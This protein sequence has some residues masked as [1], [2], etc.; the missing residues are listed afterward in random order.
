M[1]VWLEMPRHRPDGRHKASGWTT[2][3]SAFQISQKFFPEMSRVR[4]VLSCRPDSRTL[5]ARN[6]HIK[7][8][9]VW[10]KGSIV[11]TVDLMHTISIYEVR[12]S[13]PW[14]LTSGRLDFECMTCLMDERVRTGIHIVWTIAA[15]FPYLC[16]GKKYH[17]WLNTECRP[18]VLLKHPDGCKLEKFEASRHRGR[19]GR[20]VLIV[21]TDDAWTVKHLDGISRR[22][23]SCKG[24]DFTDL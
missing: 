17:S 5:A 15:V 20:K 6:F 10:T 1:S 23:D 19:S 13:E 8:W 11:L 9:R 14:G 2:V 16:F 7:G 21:R 18:D 22:L 3:R 24:S 4:T 12:A